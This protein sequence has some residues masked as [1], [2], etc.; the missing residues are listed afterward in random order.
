MDTRKL[1]GPLKYFTSLTV[2]L[3]SAGS[4]FGAASEL[5]FVSGPQSVPLLELYSSEGCSSC[6]PAERWLGDL[7]GNAG[8]W[9]EFVPIS[10]H[11]TYW[12]RLGWKDAFAHP[13]YTERQY[14]Y[15]AAW[16]ARNVHTPEFVFQGMEWR[17]G[18]KRPLPAPAGILELTRNIDGD[19]G[20][21][22]SPTQDTRSGK[23]SRE[24]I[25][26][27]VQVA[28]LGGGI[29]S[30]VKTGENSGRVLRHEFVAYSLTSAP[31]VEC[32]PKAN[33]NPSPITY[34]AKLS[35]AAMP[36]TAA[37]APSRRALVA[38]VERAGEPGP[39]QA[40]GGWL[41]E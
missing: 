31:L 1:K 28:L 24:K 40:T 22:F 2:A 19:C 9:S 27:T 39:L 16:G 11:V 4:V 5:R 41:S 15:A 36:A 8:L 34:E 23:E 17:V 12:D 13:A 7:T 6:P 38:W 25:I 10:F 33:V 26:Y 37:P 14:A 30:P 32:K 3:G 35:V 21:R 20:I 29:I 18:D